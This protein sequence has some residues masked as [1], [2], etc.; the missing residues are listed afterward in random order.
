M[1][2]ETQTSTNIDGTS[3]RKSKNSSTTSTSWVNIALINEHCSGLFSVR[4]NNNDDKA[5]LR[6]IHDTIDTDSGNVD[7]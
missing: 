5:N 4:R 1:N 3:S 7:Q 6:N 2:I